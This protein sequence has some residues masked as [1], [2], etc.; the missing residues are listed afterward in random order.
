MN[1]NVNDPDKRDKEENLQGSKS[2]PQKT[3]M[4]GL[5][6]GGNDPV[7]HSDDKPR[8]NDGKQEG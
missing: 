6:E 8:D 1:K 5:K 4:E 2:D 3:E 7:V